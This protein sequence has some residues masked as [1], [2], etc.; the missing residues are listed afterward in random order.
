MTNCVEALARRFSPWSFTYVGLYGY[1]LIDAGLHST[2]LF[3]KRGWTT[4][5]SDDLVP[6][7]ILLITLTITGLT[8]VFAHLLEHFESLKLTASQEPI[9]T[10]FM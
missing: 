4:I 9:M 6:N 1:S 2:E 10:P 7:V 8:G 5:V 3:E